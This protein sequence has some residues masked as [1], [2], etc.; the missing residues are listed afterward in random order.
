[1][2]IAD[3]QNEVKSSAN[4]VIWL[5]RKSFEPVRFAF[6]ITREHPSDHEFIHIY[7]SFMLGVSG[8]MASKARPRDT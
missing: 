1:M 5:I 4:E 3:L 2:S 8:I 6:R 7:I